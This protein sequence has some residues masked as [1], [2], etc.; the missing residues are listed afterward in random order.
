[1]AQFLKLLFQLILNPAK[2]WEDV[3][4]ALID[5]RLNVRAAYIRGF[6]PLIVCASL[7][8]FIRMLYPGGPDFLSALSRAIIDFVALF[9]SYH[10]SIYVISSMMP[11]FFDP[12]DADLAR[13]Q[14]RL[15]LT[16]MMALAF[17]SLVILV[18]N[19]IK[20]RIAILDF[21]PLY[22]IFIIWKGCGFLGISHRQEGL[23]MIVSSAAILGSVY[24][25]PIF[26]QSLV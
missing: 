2:G 17:V 26:F 1:M 24:L 8:A 19:A 22:A 20:V 11:R 6:M 21:V 3:E 4:D 15:A 25:L 16:S 18:S 10:L 9:L 23:Y 13:D 14:R 7:A 5:R 12:A